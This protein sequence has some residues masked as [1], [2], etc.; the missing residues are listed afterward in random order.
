MPTRNTGGMMFRIERVRRGSRD[1]A[2]FVIEYSALRTL[3][4]AIL[5]G[6]FALIGLLL[7][8]V[9][10]DGR[11]IGAICLL[12]FGAGAIVLAMSVGRPGRVAMLPEGVQLQSRFATV[13]A[14][15]NAVTGVGRT[16]IS[17]NE[18]LTIDVTDASRLE[19]SRGIGWLKGLN[20][21]MGMPDLALPTNLLG[22]RAGVIERAIAHYVANPEAR[23][24]IGLVEELKRLAGAIG[25]EAEG[26]APEGTADYPR[27]SRWLLW[28]TGV[29]GLLITLAASFDEPDPGREGSRIIGVVIFGT[30]C[31]AAVGSAY[32][33]RRRPRIARGL[34]L[35][36]AAGALFIGWV[37]VTDA[38]GLPRAAVGI[39][40][41]AIGLIVAWQLVRWSPPMIT[42]A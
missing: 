7:V 2:G 31:A 14:P 5:S 17:G 38:S 28:L 25:A 33:M 3:G 23:R 13:F 36:A 19:T 8:F 30:G 21:S 4:W 41:V 16:R 15:W 37:A 18:M 20:Q 34:G 22:D 26:S 29:G 9:S 10:E 35:V 40:I 24:A 12:F 32:L 1:A 27:V 42:S 39:V 11:L 6:V